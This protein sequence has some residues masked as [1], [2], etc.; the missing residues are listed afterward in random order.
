MMGQV[1]KA[2]SFAVLH[3]AGDPL[4]L[5]NI[6]DAGSAAAVAQA[7]ARAVAT[8][9]WS[10]AAAQGF[11]DGEAL[12]MEAALRTAR[13][14]VGAVDL[15]V[16]VDFE[17]GYAVEP[18]EVGENAAHLIA[19]GAVGLNFED[20]VVGGTGLHDIA[21]QTAR[22]AAI[23]TAADA[24]GVPFF[25]NART[26]VFFAD[27]PGTPDAL[28]AEAVAR[29]QAYRDAGADG[30]FAPG[31]SDLAQIAELS[32]AQPLPLNVMRMGD[33]VSVT[34]YAQ[35]GV[36]RISHGPGPYIAAMKALSSAAVV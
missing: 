9:S 1:E 26:D 15:P 5:W 16:S 32:A 2:K 6:W 30:L 18:A 7:G 35:A 13:E 4:V 25:I 3:T 14:I 21:A 28:M 8:G 11:S 33:K 36:A 34:A 27:L 19:T 22:I 10:V 17:G 23:R 29:A 24:V 12:P 20:R 31:L